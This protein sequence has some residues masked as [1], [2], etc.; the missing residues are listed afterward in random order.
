ME[1]FALVTVVAGVVINSTI[2]RSVGEGI[3][4]GIIGNRADHLFCGAWRAVVDRMR[5]GGPLVNHDLQRA[6]RKAYLQATLA[7]C[8]VSLTD[9]GAAPSILGRDV[10][11]VVKPGAEIRWLDTVRAALHEELRRI[12]HQAYAPPSSEADQQIELLLQPRDATLDERTADLC[13]ALKQRLLDELTQTHGSPPPLFTSKV[14]DG[15]ED[16]PA[17]SAARLDWFDL[18]CAFFLHELKQND[19]VAHLVQSQLLA[20]LSAAGRPLTLEVF[21]S[22]LG[23][24]GGVMVERLEHLGAQVEQ[25]RREQAEGFAAVAGRLD[26]LL[27]LL[28]LLPDL[29]ARQRA[30]S[31]LVE[32]EAERT[33]A[34]V[35]AE[36]ERVFTGL[37]RRFQELQVATAEQARA[38]QAEMALLRERMQLQSERAH[39]AA[40]NPI[41]V[42]LPALRGTFVDRQAECDTLRRLLRESDMRL[43]FIVAPGG[44]GKTELTTKVLKEVTSGT[45]ITDPHLQGI[46][47]IRCAGGDLRLGRVFSEAGRMTGQRG[48]FEQ[49]YGSNDLTLERKLE[50]FFSELGEEGNVWLV[51]DSFE[52]LLAP[53]NTIAD[54]ELGRFIQYVCEH[55]HPVR[56]LATSRAVPRFPGSQRLKPVDL[57]AGLP[58]EAA[59]TYLRAEGAECGLADAPE[60]LLREF[61][62]RVYC[63]PKALESVVGYLVERYPVVQ[64][65]DLMADAALFADFDRYDA[66]NGLKRLIAEQFAGQ[67]PDAKLGLSI[68]SVFRKPAPLSALRFMLPA[69]DW[70]GV[71]PPLER[72]RLVS[73]QGDRY[74]LHPLVREF[75]Y[76][77]IPEQG[78]GQSPPSSFSRSALHARA[79]EFYA[80]IR[81]PAEQWKTVDDLQPQLDEFHH[82]VQAG[83]YDEA[84]QVLDVIDG[85]S[86]LLWGHAR[87]VLELREP[88]AGN[89]KDP[90]LAG[91]NAYRMGSASDCL[92]EARK[93]IE[94]YEQALA[95][96]HETDDRQGQG[97][98]LDSLGTAYRNLGEPREAIRYFEQALAIHRETGDRRGEADDLGNLGLAYLNLGEP[99]NAA[100]Y[101]LQALTIRHEIGDRQGEAND[102]GSL[103]LA[104]TSL[105][106]LREGIR[107]LEQVLAIRREIGDRQGEAS[108]LG[109][110]GAAYLSLGEVR[111][112]ITHLQQAL[113]VHREIGNRRGEARDLSDLGLAHLSLGEAQEAMAC[114]QQAL[115]F[116]R[117]I[118]NRRGEASAL[119]NL[120]MAHHHRDDLGEARRCYERGLAL[121]IP[122]T[123][124]DCA[125]MLGI[126]CLE[127]GKTR[128]AEEYLQQSITLSQGLLEKTPGLYKPLYALA[129]AQLA[130]RQPEAA[131]AAY[132]Q[133]LAAC[134]APGVLEN[135]LWELRLLERAAESVDG[136][137]EAVA[138]LQR[139]VPE[140]PAE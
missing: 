15:W 42:P 85:D 14:R 63:I 30:L 62:H 100:T 81:L 106:D 27:P 65:E 121:D 34:H 33:R 4:G 68:L 129:L 71:L 60:E 72:N 8:E 25:M 135:A 122:K 99:R 26:D 6:V 114:F 87:L 76:G 97:D 140:A 41:P 139:A 107:R 117:E 3:V 119:L 124:Y 10:R 108:D 136:L 7:V 123:H 35:T 89:L 13:R 111:K 20:G 77:R 53:D 91:R 19:A 32:R 96:H 47:Y 70:A 52:D 5:R 127:E 131:F 98:V 125:V 1:P 48:G 29:Q 11:H 126:L 44:Y 133:A 38:Q 51:L 40:R 137:A 12:P 75:V 132:G 56:L 59:V 82:R 134:S 18:L 130:G 94:H 66:E 17:N 46:L 31:G 110:L 109:A 101:F 74:D 90:R 128:E 88:L 49:T 23:Q 104:Y 73:R 138:L 54:P 50:F 95:I 120:G 21:Q 118:G 2:A 78:P 61:V 9:L 86:L 28:A 36:A 22:E 57:R 55:E 79:A 83:Q 67:T 103:G 16:G 84:A 69:L 115:A 64:L 92:G 112:A 113:A 45:R 37:D 105:G 24:M 58:E 102:L 93:A 80:R 39:A 43:I 116:N